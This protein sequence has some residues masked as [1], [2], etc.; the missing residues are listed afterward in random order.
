MFNL[1]AS[2]GF[3]CIDVSNIYKCRY[4]SVTQETSVL[5]V[6]LLTDSEWIIPATS[7]CIFRIVQPKALKNPKYFYILIYVTRKALKNCKRDV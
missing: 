2:K 5:L 3:F 7:F 1:Q 6:C 4:W